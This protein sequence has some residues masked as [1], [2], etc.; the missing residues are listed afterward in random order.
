MAGSALWRANRLDRARRGFYFLRRLGRH[1]HY[2]LGRWRGRVMVVAGGLRQQHPGHRGG[3][4]V[5]GV[6]GGMRGGKGCHFHDC[7]VAYSV[8]Y[9]RIKAPHGMLR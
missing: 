6:F 1:I 9:T 3:G 8:C 5:S 4:Y 2:F 7:I